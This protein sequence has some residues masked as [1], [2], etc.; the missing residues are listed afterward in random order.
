[1]Y[2]SCK[3]FL[4]FFKKTLNFETLWDYFGIIAI[5]DSNLFFCVYYSSQ[6]IK[7]DT[8]FLILKKKNENLSI[9]ARIPGMW[10]LSVFVQLNEQGGRFLILCCQCCVF[11]EVQNNPYDISSFSLKTFDNP[12]S[13]NIHKV[14]TNNTVQRISSLKVFCCS[15]SYL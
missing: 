6:V 10:R 9:E 13:T 15:L 3:T 5:L 2:F 14:R 1:M 4:F 8:S 7:N 11:E 12:L